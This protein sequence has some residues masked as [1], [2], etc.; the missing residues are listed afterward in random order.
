[1]RVIDPGH[2]YRLRNYSGTPDKPVDKDDV[3]QSLWFMHRIGDRY[4]GNEGRPYD[5]TNLQEVFR[6]LID[7]V[8]YLDNQIPCDENKKIVANLRDN[9]LLLEIRAAREHGTIL[10][11]HHIPANIEMVPTCRICGHILC[12]HSLEN[13]R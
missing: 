3:E 8:N 5:G 10:N 13:F 6:T 12:K 1:M 9:I 7:R 2:Y 4:P 11:T